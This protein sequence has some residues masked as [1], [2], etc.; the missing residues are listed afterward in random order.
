ML[1]LMFLDASLVVTTCKRLLNLFVNI[2]TLFGLQSQMQ[3]AVLAQNFQSIVC[4]WFKSTPSWYCYIR[5]CYI[6]SRHDTG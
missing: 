4:S 6:S 1:L 2:S 5:Y 3:Q